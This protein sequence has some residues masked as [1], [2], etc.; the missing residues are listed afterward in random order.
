MLENSEIVLETADARLG[1]DAGSGRLVRFEPAWDA[2]QQFIASAADHPVFVLQYLD[3]GRAY[4]TVD[5]FAAGTVGIECEAADGG[6]TLTMR[7]EGVGGMDLDVTA[8]VRAW[9]DQTMSRWS[10]A[11]R[12]GAGLEIVDVQYPFVVTSYR[13]GGKPNGEALLLPRDIGLLIEEPKPEDLGPDSVEAWRFGPENSVAVRHGH[14]ANSQHYPGA[15]FAQFMAYHNES[16]GLY[17]A[18]EDT[19]GH[20]KMLHALH[21]DPGIRM[22]MAHVGDWP[23]EG[24]RAMEYDVLMGAYRG[25]WYTAAGIYRDWSLKQKWG[26]PLHERKDVPDWIL[27]SP[28]HITIRTQGTLDTGP[29]FPVEEFLPYEKCVPMLEKISQR[30]ESALVAVIMSWERGGPWVYPD[31]FP[32]IGGEESVTAFAKMARERGWHVGSFCNGTRWVLGHF[33]NQYD[34]R[35]YYEKHDGASSV[36][37]TLEGE[38]WPEQWDVDWRPSYGGCMGT[39]LTCDIATDFVKRLIG[40]GME[41]V[42][43]FDQN[44]GA[45]TFP[46]LATDHDHPAVPGRW[47]NDAMANLVKRFHGEAEAAGED[48]V[49]QSVEFQC[50]EYCLPLFQQ[51][52]VRLSPKGTGYPNV[53]PLYHF[54]FHECIILHGMMGYGPEP[55]HLPI[56]NALNGVLGEIPGGAMIGDGTL[57]NKNTVNWAPWEPRVG[58]DD[59]ALEMIRTVTALRRGAGRPFMVYGRLQ[60]PAEVNGIETICWD[61]EVNHYEMPA[62]FHAAW[63]SPDD[64]FGV[65]LA[66]WTTEARAV[67]VADERLGGRATCHVAGREMVDQEA[68]EAA[69]GVAVALPPLSCAVVVGRG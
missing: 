37:R 55:Y 21:L 31:C 68:V 4:Q 65:V 40:W 1:F 56:R 61:R 30:V 12:N 32:P 7:F 33:W 42:Q 6:Q 36:C 9:S 34:G 45:A 26:T 47:M 29:V 64:A 2:G 66:N 57:L 20:I 8:T 14:G 3:E 25:D 41:S 69:D 60:R 46:C 39:A 63:T 13:P 67:A 16:A 5:S 11:V 24:E 28:V 43:F 51:C 22:G 53:V 58:S 17:M 38:P 62:V 35:E 15:V 50:N 44:L 49:L 48:G 10:I 27:E 19:D 18:C 23:R 52:D 54:L 59:D